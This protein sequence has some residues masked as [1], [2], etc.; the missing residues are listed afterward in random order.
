MSKP[1][2]VFVAGNWK[3]NHGP[4]AAEAFVSELAAGTTGFQKKPGLRAALLAPAV[5]LAP[6]K[7][8]VAALPALQ[9]FL[10]VG[11]QNAHHELSGAYT[12]ELSGQ[13]LK[14]IG[15]TLTLVGHSERRQHFGETDESSC[16]RRALR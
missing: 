3:M 2:G 8:A 1:R 9:G 14:E 16:Q 7:Q 15:I 5:T 13:L 6:A 11:A 4:A 10:E 12:G